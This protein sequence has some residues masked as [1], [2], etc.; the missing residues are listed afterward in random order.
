MAVMNR[1]PSHPH[2]LRKWTDS[3]VHYR[4]SDRGVKLQ[5]NAGAIMGAFLLIL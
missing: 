5:S 3:D 4:P 2:Y 1:I